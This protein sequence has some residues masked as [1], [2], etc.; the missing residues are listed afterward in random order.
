MK[1]QTLPTLLSVASA[2][3]LSLVGAQAHAETLT[4]EMAY[5]IVAKADD[6]TETLIERDSVRPG[7][8]IEFEII[9]SNGTE[10]SIDGLS[11]ALPVPAGVTVILGEETSSVPAAFEVQAE[12]DPETP[13]L[14][15]STLPASRTVIETDGTARTEP[16]PADAV[17]A[18]RW[19]LEAALPSGEMT[20]NA[21][22]VVVN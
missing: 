18:V 16:L 20:R 9:H 12:M 19:N 21:Y 4:S 22:R 7:E 10:D 5:R 13:G 11:V 8:T 6:G 14:E 15:W 1:T 2:V 3:C 17:T